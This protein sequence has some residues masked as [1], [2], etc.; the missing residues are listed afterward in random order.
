MASSRGRRDAVR[1]FARAALTLASRATYLLYELPTLYCTSYVL[2]HYIAGGQGA[3]AGQGQL[4][5]QPEPA[6]TGGGATELEQRAAFARQDDALMCHR[7]TYLFITPRASTAERVSPRSRVHTFARGLLRLFILYIIRN[8]LVSKA[9]VFLKPEAR[10][11][12][13]ERPRVKPPNPREVTTARLEAQ[14]GGQLPV[15]PCQLAF[16]LRNMT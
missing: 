15:G 2:T 1:C 3:R 12:A 13:A 9:L 16:N 5:E 11:S 8:I 14:P 4:G 7:A 6:A 10:T